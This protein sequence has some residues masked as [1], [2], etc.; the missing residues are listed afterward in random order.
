MSRAVSCWWAERS[1]IDRHDRR[2]GRR[3]GRPGSTARPARSARPGPRR[4]PPAPPRSPPPPPTTVVPAVDASMRL[5]SSSGTHCSVHA[6]LKV[7]SVRPRSAGHRPGHVEHGEPVE[8]GAA[9]AAAVGAQVQLDRLLGGRA[10]QAQA[11]G[12]GHE[13][14]GQ[15]HHRRVR[16]GPSPARRPRPAARPRRPAAPAS[17]PHST[18][19]AASVTSARPASGRPRRAARAWARPTASMTPAGEAGRPSSRRQRATFTSH[20]AMTSPS[21]PSRRRRTGGRTSRAR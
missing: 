21:A 4:R 3:A 9:P 16:R 17:P 15:R 6:S 1:A 10:G 13:I 14:G 12:R 8:Q 2:R 20:E 5:T 18:A 11:L 19:W 7:P